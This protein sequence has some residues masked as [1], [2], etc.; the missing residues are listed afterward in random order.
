MS[1]L[2]L[3]K[4]CNGV[5]ANRANQL[6]STAQGHYQQCQTRCYVLIQAVRQD[7]DLHFGAPIPRQ[8]RIPEVDILLKALKNVIELCFTYVRQ[9]TSGPMLEWGALAFEVKNRALIVLAQW[10]EVFEMRPG[11]DRLCC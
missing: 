6:T 8:S 1:L 11:Q 2:Q 3:F 4:P 7:L 9:G 5:R 10:M